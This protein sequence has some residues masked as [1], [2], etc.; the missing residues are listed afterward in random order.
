MCDAEKGN[1]SSLA[2]VICISRLLSDLNMEEVSSI[3]DEGLFAY[4][5]KIAQGGKKPL[6]LER[7]ISWVKTHPTCWSNFIFRADFGTEDLEEQVNKVKAGIEAGELPAE[8]VIGPDTKP[9]GLYEYL[10]S[11]GYEKKYALAGMAADLTILGGKAGIPQDVE[12]RAA[13]NEELLHLWTGVVSQ[14]LFHGG[15]VEACLFEKLLTDSSFRF[16]L[17]FSDGRAV[18]SSMLQLY[19]GN[20]VINMVATLPEYRGRG[21][22]TAMTLTPLLEAREMGCTI[23]VLQASAAG[24]PVYRKIGFKEYCRFHV[25]KLI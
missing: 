11:H 10:I 16:Y 2:E 15:S 23:G 18:A 25:C 20:A 14:G 19:G 4:C 6:G 17:A 13:D 8:W 24:E 1:I 12:V 5:V 3:I 9:E 22:G 7:N 21:I